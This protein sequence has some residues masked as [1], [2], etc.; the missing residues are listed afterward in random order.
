MRIILSTVRPSSS[1]APPGATIHSVST[2]SHPALFPELN[3]GARII[4]EHVYLGLRIRLGVSEGAV[5][6][7]PM[8]AHPVECNLDHLNGC[9]WGALC[10]S[11]TVTHIL[12]ELTQLLTPGFGSGHV[13]GLFGPCSLEANW[14]L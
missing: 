6:H 1:Q 10:D 12:L 2:A 3:S 7:P 14:Q 4:D 11:R 8:V 13:K 9:M 5:D